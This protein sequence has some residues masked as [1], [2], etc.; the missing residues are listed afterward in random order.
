MQYDTFI[1][2]K[3]L[4]AATWGFAVD[5]E[6]INEKLFPFQRD[7]VQWALSMGKAAIFAE[8]GLGKTAIELTWADH[9][10]RHTGG[11]VLILT[12]L[13]VAHQHVREG[14]KFD[15]DAIYCRSQEAA[16]SASQSVII[17]N[18]EM[19]SAFNPDYFAGIVLDESSILKAY[20][21][22][23]KKQILDSFEHT[24]YKLAA[25][26]TPAPNDHLELGNHAEFLNVMA[27]NEMISRWFINNS[28]KAG[29]YRLKRHAAFKFWSW[30]TTWAVCLSVPS[31][32]GEQYSDEGY[33]LPP[34]N[35]TQE[36]VDVDHTRA[37]E[38]GRLVLDDS[39]S[40][41]GMWKEKRQTAE[42]RCKRAAEIVLSDNESTWI[43]WCDTNDEADLLQ[44]LLPEAVEVRGNH[45]IAEKERKLSAFS[46]GE[47]RI[48]ITKAD[49][50]GFG[51]NWQHCNNQVFAGMTHSFEKFYQ[52]LGRSYRFGQTKPVNAYVIY[53]ESEG[54]IMES[55]KEKQAAFTEMQE[56]MNAAM[57]ANGF[58]ISGQRQHRTEVEES[59][60]A[61]EDF[62]LYLGDCVSSMRHVPDNSIGFS[63]FSPP[64]A[65]LYIYSDSIADMGNCA[66]YDEFQ[67]HY[68][69]LAAELMRVMMPGRLVAIHCKDLPKYMNRDGA[70][71]LYDFPSDLRVSMER[72]GFVYHSRVTIWKDPVT[73]MQR[74]KNHGL[75]HR[76]F[77]E[78][79]EVVRQ[80]MADYILVFRKWTDDMP[81]K[82]IQHCIIVPEADLDI[83]ITEKM[84]AHQ[85]IGTDAPKNYRDDRDYSIQVWQ[86]YA[87]PVWFDIHQQNVLNFRIAKDDQDEKHICP[88]QL[89]VIERCIWLWSNPGET[90]LSPFAGVGSEGYV[91]LKMRRKFVGIEL[92]RSYWEMAQNHLNIALAERNQYTLFD[93]MAIAA[94]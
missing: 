41:T 94:D 59:I 67:Q 47:A 44:A 49:I 64:F 90:V 84:D 86:R 57:R 22:K 13:A 26:A 77:T 17:A 48:I 12:P 6:T 71:G 18:Y 62:T 4:R 1:D 43:V 70:A 20:T 27:S 2:S 76:N 72:A 38:T 87:S 79:A 69:F 25:T 8:R 82:Q 33:I 58:S 88:L 34:L 46:D 29:D 80:G 50:A 42:D 9:V 35:I 11:K 3:R 78:R 68:D 54:N 40:A 89:D 81:D 92:K 14:V 37:F 45:S 15:V 66:D 39:P 51:L 83:A 24:P 52:A 65:N 85:Y 28:M 91:S 23:T 21:G 16:E 32:L 53:S 30:V 74:T 56:Q 5:P 31:D 10:A 36:I 19:L 73:E 7:V 55:I 75:L 63:V 61:G 93:M 60:A